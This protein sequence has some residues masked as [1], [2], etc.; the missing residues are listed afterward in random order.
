MRFVFNWQDVCIARQAAWF[1]MW[2]VTHTLLKYIRAV[3]YQGSTETP[4]D[5]ANI[6][7]FTLVSDTG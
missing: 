7:I 2:N 4:V 5:Q 1:V 6:Y 3:G